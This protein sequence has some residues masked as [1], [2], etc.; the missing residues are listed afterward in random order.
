[1]F[2][3]NLILAL[4]LFL[5][6]IAMAEGD[7]TYTSKKKAS[8][9]IPQP[10]GIEVGGGS[11]FMAGLEWGSPLS[12]IYEQKRPEGKKGLWAPKYAFVWS[13]RT[14]YVYDYIDH[15]HGVLLNPNIQGLYAV[16]TGVAVGPQVGW[17]SST[18]FD[19]GV[20]VR[21]DLIGMLNIEA[22]YFFEKKNLYVSFLFSFS[23]LRFGPFDP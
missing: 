11:M 18:G 4:A 2:V 1:M 7:S 10:L 8:D 15:E 17:F 12:L 5:P 19:Y 21:L 9:Y 3:R 23:M 20:S 22:G 16:F 14:R 6:S 13:I